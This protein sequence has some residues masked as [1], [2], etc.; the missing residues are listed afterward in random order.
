MWDFMV[1]KADGLVALRAV[2]VE[3]EVLLNITV[4]AGFA[5]GI[6]NYAR[7]II[8]LMDDA[9]VFK[10][11]QRAVEGGAVCP[12]GLALGD[13]KGVFYIAQCYGH[14]ALLHEPMDKD[15]HRRGAYVAGLKSFFSGHGGLFFAL[16]VLQI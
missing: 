14:L 16:S 6:F 12:L 8:D 3:V 9:L 4:A 1:C 15:T 2:K 5:Q 7:A 11:L 13:G 10:G